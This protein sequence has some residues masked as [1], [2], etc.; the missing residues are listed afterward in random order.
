MSKPD[1]WF[2]Y[3]TNP[4]ISFWDTKA[5]TERISDFPFV[6]SFAYIRDETNHMADIILPEATD[7]ESLQVSRI[8][9]TGSGEQFWK[10]QGWMI[11]QPAVEPTVDAM[12]MTDIATEICMRV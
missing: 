8:G 12:D 4:A 3:R 2:V 7:L 9:G 5:V 1:L 10:H 6:V 11:R